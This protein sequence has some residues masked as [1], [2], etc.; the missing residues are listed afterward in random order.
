MKREYVREATPEEVEERR[1]GK[2]SGWVP[3]TRL[4]ILVKEG[5][6]KSMEEV[7]ESKMRIMEPEIADTLLSL[8]EEYINIGQSKGK[9]GGGKRRL[10]RQT[11]RKTAEGNVP[12]FGCLIIIGDMQGHVGVGYGK[13]SETLPAREKALRDA[14][15]NIIKVKRG[16]GSFDCACNEEHSIPLK[17]SGKCSS[18]VVELLPAP[19]GVGLVVEDELK[20][21]LRLAGIK[22]VYSRTYGEG[23]TKINMVKACIEALQK[24]SETKY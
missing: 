2:I 13:A 11:Q 7:F 23:R 5:K 4:G 3:R 14:K 17:V 8:Q 12:S 20:K 21:I 9:F 19:K 15:L 6:I 1:K 10:W 22:D 16:C 24:T 18:S